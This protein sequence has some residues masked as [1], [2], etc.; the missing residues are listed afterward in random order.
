MC[1]SNRTVTSLRTKLIYFVYFIS[2]VGSPI[3]VEKV[4]NPTQ[5]IIDNLHSR[6]IAELTELYE[7]H[8]NQYHPTDKSVLMIV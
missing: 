3:P 7:K 6:Y 4:V 8:K 2:A 1:P 5:E